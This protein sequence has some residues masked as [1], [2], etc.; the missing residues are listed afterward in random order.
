M[1]NP[2]LPARA[3]SAADRISDIANVPRLG[4]CA[5][6]LALGMAAVGIALPA[7]ADFV[8][9][10]PSFEGSDLGGAGS[11]VDDTVLP[12][13][14]GG[15][16]PA[17]ALLDADDT[18]IEDPDGA[19]WPPTATG[20]E[21]EAGAEE[22]PP[23]YVSEP[24]EEWGEWALVICACT[25]YASLDLVLLE[26][27]YVYDYGATLTLAVDTVVLGAPEPLNLD[28]SVALAG[29]LGG[30]SPV[31][32]PATLALLPFGLAARAVARRRA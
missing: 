28:Y 9:S 18:M 12:P 6:A 22:I 17:G 27:L 14:F 15:V 8:L 19:Q 31:P 25:Y 4:A 24:N 20:G 5:L 7:R 13:D 23:E 11:G 16:P 3:A 26:P 21:E 10:D 32:V 2:T 29:V 1:G 30:P